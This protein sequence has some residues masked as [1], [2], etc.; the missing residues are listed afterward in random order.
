MA[1][2]FTYVGQVSGMTV[3]SQKIIAGGTVEA[4]DLLA[5]DRAKAVAA[6]GTLSWYVLEG[7]ASGAEITVLP[8]IPGMIFKGTADGDVATLGLAVS[9]AGT[10]TQVIDA[11][12]GA[13]TAFFRA[14]DTVDVSAQADDSIR[15]LY[16]GHA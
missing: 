5:A 15:V 14:L 8:V 11:D 13:G 2:D 4:G 12:A 3:S 1:K 16:V 10:T 9:L 6:D 7:G